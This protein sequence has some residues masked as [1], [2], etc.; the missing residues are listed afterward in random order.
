MSKTKYDYLNELDKEGKLKEYARKGIIDPAFC[1]SIEVFRLV[2][3][4]KR[5]GSTSGEA[6]TEAAG[7]FKMCNRSI[8]RIIKDL[9]Q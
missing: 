7:C 5:T 1:T 2:D 6:I 8:Y 4:R 9:N 3:M